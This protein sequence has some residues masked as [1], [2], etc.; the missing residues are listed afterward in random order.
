LSIDFNVYSVSFTLFLNN[1]VFLSNILCITT[2]DKTQ[3]KTPLD[4]TLLGT[5]FTHGK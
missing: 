4:K 5:I 1:C 2:K 3:Q